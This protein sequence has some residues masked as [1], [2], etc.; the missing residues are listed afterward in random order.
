MK[1]DYRSRL[2]PRSGPSEPA[3]WGEASNY[4]MRLGPKGLVVNDTEK[5]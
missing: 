1:E 2:D 4:R 3:L 5:A